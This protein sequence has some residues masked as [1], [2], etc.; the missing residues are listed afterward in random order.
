MKSEKKISL[1]ETEIKNCETFKQ[2][3][4]SYNMNQKQWADAT[5]ISYGLV[6]RIEA[7][8]IKCSSK[9]KTKVRNF[10]EQNQN[11]PDQPDL[12]DLEAHILFD[13]FL[14]HLNQVSKKEAS[15]CAGRCTKALQG[16]L[17][18]APK[19]DS[20][21]AQKVYFQF[22]EQVFT[23]LSFASSDMISEISKGTDI[24][25]INK[26]MKNIFT[27]K[28]ITKYKNSADVI[29]SRNGD[30]SRQYNLSEFFDL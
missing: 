19:C 12:H 4:I 10:M 21:S 5:G 1:T 6:K 9:T 28:L 13:I 23:A 22:L 27:G 26:G 14:T 3:R 11:T 18:Y 30:V 15:I 17:S 16:I 25:N 29:V 20:S 7:H 8:T 2:I 24:L